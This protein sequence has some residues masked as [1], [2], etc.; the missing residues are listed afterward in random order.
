MRTISSYNRFLE[1]KK[2]NDIIS[3]IDNSVNESIDINDI[4]NGVV[5]KIKNL[6]VESKKKILNHTLATL[7]TLSVYSNVVNIV[8]K[9]RNL[10]PQLKEFSLDILGKQKEDIAKIAEEKK[11]KRG[12]EFTLSQEGWDHIRK[13]NLYD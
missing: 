13:R 3:F 7:L 4:W 11:W 12:Y 2:V 8:N 9:T 1:E 10:E 5:N 6:S